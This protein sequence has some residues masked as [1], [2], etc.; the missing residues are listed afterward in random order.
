MKRQLRTYLSVLAVAMLLLSAA[1]SAGIP[2]VSADGGKVPSLAPLIDQVSPAVVNISTKGTIKTESNPLMQDPFFRHFFNMPEQQQERQFHALGSGVIINADK[3]YIL[4]NHHVIQH[5]DQIQVTL[6]DNRSF[7]A[8]VIGSD[9]E[10]D[11]AVIQI[12][13]DNLTEIPVANSDDIRVGDYVVAIGNPFGLDHTVTTGVVSGLGRQLRGGDMGNNRLQNFIQTDASINPGN[14]G[15]ALI[16]LKGQLV[17][18]NTAILSQSGG[19]IGIGFAI[20]INMAQTVM[21]QIIKYGEVRRGVLGVRVQNLTPEIA[22]AM[23]VSQNEGALVAQVSP[24]SAAEKAGIKQG[25]VITE[26]NGEDIK[27]ANDLAT[28]IGLMQVGEKLNITLYRDGEEKH[29][30]AKVGNPKEHEAKAANLNPALAGATFSNLDERSPLFGKVEG[31]LVTDVD[32]NSKAA[33]Y[34]QPGDVITSVN[35]APVKSLAGFREKVKGKD[36]LLLNIRRGNAAM[37]VLIK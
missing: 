28:V 25:D 32:A 6:N 23:D 12:D 33:N 15:G 29:V 22:K 30:T 16:N 8:K 34:L 7:E 20:P 4:T 14:S 31:V 10:T 1:A 5:A 27:S 9:P 37:F 24:N 17:G 21:K 26:V 36:R 13:A 19:N 18:I 2:P 3:G 11:I 35:R